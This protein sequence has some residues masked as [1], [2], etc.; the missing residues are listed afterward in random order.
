M[1]WIITIVQLT[2]EGF[3]GIEMKN[4]L[5]R[6]PDLNFSYAEKIEVYEHPY[7]TRTSRH[8]S[9]LLQHFQI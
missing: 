1:Y 3:I 7:K 9:S 4:S 6:E 8:D 2:V 5:N